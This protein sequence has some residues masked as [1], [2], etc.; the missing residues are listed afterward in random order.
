MKES[1]Y[2]RISAGHKY[3]M[4]IDFTLPPVFFIAVCPYGSA[5]TNDSNAKDLHDYTFGI[6]SDPLTRFACILSALIHDL[7]KCF[8]SSVY[9]SVLLLGETIG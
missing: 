2:R 5:P 4:I 1:D 3:L 7:G 6:T 8:F 9:Y